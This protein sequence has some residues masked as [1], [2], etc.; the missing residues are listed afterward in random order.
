MS[1]ALDT[2]ILIYAEGLNDEAKARTVR[3]LL[4][5]IPLGAVHVPMQVCAELHRALTRKFGWPAQRAELAVRSWGRAAQVTPVSPDSFSE[6]L[7]LTTNHQLQIFD[8][9]ILTTAASDRCQVL[10]SEDMHHGFA[11]RG[12]TVVNPFT[13][14]HHPA[15]ATALRPATS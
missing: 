3:T 15:L 9:M 6:A 10:M 1:V 12:G 5:R 7:S 8:A 4:D 11:W 2:N 14:P 13:L